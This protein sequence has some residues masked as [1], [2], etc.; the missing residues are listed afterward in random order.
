VQGS[1]EAKYE[2]GLVETVDLALI[3]DDLPFGQLSSVAG[4]AAF[5]YLQR[6][7]SFTAGCGIDAICTAPLNKEALHAGGTSFPGTR[8]CLPT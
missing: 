7:V 5:Q 6:A 4:D 2:F 3:P 1:E 8:N